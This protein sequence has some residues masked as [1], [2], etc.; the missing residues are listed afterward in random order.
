[1]NMALALNNCEAPNTAAAGGNAKKA[2]AGA[3]IAETAEGFKK[4]LEDCEAVVVPITSNTTSGSIT[5]TD[6]GIQNQFRDNNSR[7]RLYDRRT[8]DTGSSVG[9]H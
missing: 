9:H 5:N 8:R 1:M 6:E 3:K 2:E 4:K 7:S